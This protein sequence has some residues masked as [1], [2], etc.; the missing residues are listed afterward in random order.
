MGLELEMYGGN[1]TV[2]ETILDKTPVLYSTG[3]KIL[4]VYHPVFTKIRSRITQ[5][6]HTLYKIAHQKPLYNLA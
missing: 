3:I 1:R 5:I 2:M 4:G 6:S